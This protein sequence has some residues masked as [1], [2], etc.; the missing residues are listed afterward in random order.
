[1]KTTLVQKTGDAATRT[2]AAMTLVIVLALAQTACGS[3]SED[4]LR[5]QNLSL[6][7]KDQNANSGCTTTC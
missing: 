2:I 5:R 7:N 6:I 4:E 1:M 3:E